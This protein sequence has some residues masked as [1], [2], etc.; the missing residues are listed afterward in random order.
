M[1][2]SP[3]DAFA[4][5]PIFNLGIF[6]ANLTL[7]T[8]LGLYLVIALVFIYLLFGNSVASHNA[9]STNPINKNSNTALFAFSSNKATFT[10]QLFNYFNL[11]L[12]EASI[13]RNT[14]KTSTETSTISSTKLSTQSNQGLIGGHLDHAYNLAI[15]NL[16]LSKALKA[17]KTKQTSS[18]SNNSKTLS[19]NF[20]NKFQSTAAAKSNSTKKVKDTKNDSKS[21]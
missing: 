4:I 17:A 16:N 18:T 9:S 7:L 14:N 1:D 6:N 5:N 10:D 15:N 19:I 11:M 2:F 13:L 3:L 8:N 21:K 20:N 12:Q